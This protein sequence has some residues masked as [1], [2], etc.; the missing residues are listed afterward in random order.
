[1]KSRPFIDVSAG[2]GRQVHDPNNPATAN[3]I[4]VELSQDMRRAVPTDPNLGPPAQTRRRGRPFSRS[5]YYYFLLRQAWPFVAIIL[6]LGL[7]INYA[8]LSYNNKTVESWLS[9]GE[10]KTQTSVLQKTLDQVIQYHDK[11]D[12]KTVHAGGQLKRY[13]ETSPVYG[14][15]LFSSYRTGA[16]KFAA[17]GLSG[18]VLHDSKHLGKCLW[19]ERAGGHRVEGTLQGFYPGEHHNLKYESIVIV[20][21]LEESTEHD[22]GGELLMNID[23]ED[24]VVY[25]EEAGTFPSAEPKAPF[26]YNLAYCSTPVASA[27]DG[28]KLYEWIEYH[29]DQG[30]DYLVVYDAGGID[31]AAMA[32]L[33]AYTAKGI[34]EVV[35]TRKVVEY[36]LWLFG[37]VMLANDCAYRTRFTAKWTM[38]MDFNEYFSSATGVTL[39]KFLDTHDG[40]PYVTFG[41]QWWSLEKCLPDPSGTL[42]AVQRMVYHWPDVYCV[43][44]NEYPRWS[45]CLDYYGYRKYAVDPRKISALQIHRSEVP[46]SGGVDVDTDI[47]R[48]NRWQ[49]LVEFNSKACKHVVEPSEVIDWWVQDSQVAVT[50]N[51]AKAHSVVP[52]K[53]V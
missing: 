33:E 32:V 12:A 44:K 43:N 18:L 49:G 53:S 39:A 42:W 52:Y 48:L 11:A 36:N 6:G 19:K 20:C 24:I 1:M 50:A 7:L 9:K 21:T 22:L 2:A 28:K 17:V 16:A 10:D 25:T 8:Y 26:K 34:V 3:Q 29:I 35:D 13:R 14:F 4:S 38:F 31:E 15:I 41:S 46:R 47:A 37:T 45:L 51:A 27:L 30:I 23:G 5:L 40:Q